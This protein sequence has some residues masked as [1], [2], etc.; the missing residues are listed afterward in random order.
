MDNLRT[1]ETA[2]LLRV[3]RCKLDLMSD[4]EL[5]AEIELYSPRPPIMDFSQPVNNQ[6][7][8][9]IDIGKE[10]RTA[11]PMTRGATPYIFN[12]AISHKRAKVL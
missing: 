1:F 4:E 9:D 10:W 6:C 5:Q 3:N 2:R 12:G 11:S 8:D 7:H